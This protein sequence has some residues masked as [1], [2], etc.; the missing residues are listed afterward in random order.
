MEVDQCVLPPCGQHSR[1]KGL[2]FLQFIY[3]NGVDDLSAGEADVSGPLV[4]SVGRP[5]ATV[6][7]AGF[8][9]DD[10]PPEVITVASRLCGGQKSAAMSPYAGFECF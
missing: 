9:N 6:L 1:A 8:R 5:I 7:L 10:N 3:R 2:P 4:T